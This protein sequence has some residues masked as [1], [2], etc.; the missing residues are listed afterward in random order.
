MVNPFSSRN[1]IV[2]TF[3]SDDYTGRPEDYWQNYKAKMEA[4]TPEDVLAAA[5]KYLHPEHLVYLVVGDPE[6]VL[7]GSD[8]HDEQYSDFG[9]ITMLPARD[10]MSLEVK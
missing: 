7:K 3:A 5:Q 4:V 6:A 1:A 2:R 10:P 9:A 8:K